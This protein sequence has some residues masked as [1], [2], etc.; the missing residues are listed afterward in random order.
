MA[1]DLRDALDVPADPQF[2][3]AFRSY[4]ISSSEIAR[5]VCRSLEAYL[6]GENEPATTFFEN[7]STLNLEHI[8]PRSADR[9]D[10]SPDI[11][12]GYYKRVGNLTLLDPRANTEIGNGLFIEKKPTYKASPFLLTAQLTKYATWGTTEIDQRQTELASYAPK[13]WPLTWEK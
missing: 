8:L 4:S 7:A 9:W 12:K 3:S 13:V 6:R 11:A 2:Q 10:I 1:R 5:Y